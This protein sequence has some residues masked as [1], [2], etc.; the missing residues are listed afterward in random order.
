MKEHVNLLTEASGPTF[1]F[2][3]ASVSSFLRHN[4]WFK[5]E[6]RIGTHPRSSLS[7]QQQ[8]RLRLVYERVS[9][10]ELSLA[11]GVW[12]SG[13]TISEKAIVPFLTGLGTSTFL[14]ITR[15][16]LY[17][18]SRAVF[19]GDVSEMIIPNR[20]ISARHHQ[21]VIFF[22]S[23]TPLSS[24]RAGEE[25]FSKLKTLP[26]HISVNFGELSST[27]PDKRFKILQPKLKQQ[28]FVI[29]DTF[30]T[31]HKFHSK[32]NGI[33]NRETQEA[34]RV[35]YLD[36]KRNLPSRLASHS[37][38][39]DKNIARQLSDLSTS[40]IIPAYAAASYIE[41]CLDSIVNQTDSIP[42]E[43]LV[44]VDNCKS[45]SL[46]LAKIRHKYQNLRVFKTTI[47]S[48]P[49]L[50]RNTLSKL[51]HHPNL[52]FFD[53]DDLMKP[54]MLQ[55]IR[56]KANSTSQVR[57]KYLNFKGNS[58]LDEPMEISNQT[59]HGV[60][61]IPAHIFNKVGGFQP[62]PFGADTEFMKRCRANKLP[63]VNIDL[64]LF[65][66]RIHSSSL[67]QN[68]QTGYASQSR[69]RV[70]QWIKNNKDWRI[71]IVTQIAE[72][73]KDETSISI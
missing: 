49:Y 22:D 12:I 8:A 51:A 3:L 64:P 48:G 5:G 1:D 57:F 20:I 23:E 34:G 19:L 40:I 68:S 70:Q 59:A 6:L 2:T 71:P 36:A 56:T 29:F 47:Q 26:N 18:S 4:P 67:T 73:I 13:D 42:V 61:F 38:H 16:T 9:F 62:W 31:T 50:I 44:G 32:I 28:K 33:W 69:K 11:R 46:E 37:I 39:S 17:F 43:I 55:L 52:L 54:D 45:T 58:I 14:H 7:S 41:A 60:F 27:F 72:M 63:V 10:F 24:L 25:I 35:S 65:Y 15:G 66:R 30:K 53:A 21:S